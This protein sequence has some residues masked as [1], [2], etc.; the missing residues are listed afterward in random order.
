MVG[1]A[2]DDVVNDRDAHDLARLAQLRR[3]FQ[4]GVAG[5]AVAGGM[6]V[7]Q[8]HAGGVVED[9]GAEQFARMHEAGRGGADGDGMHGN[10]LHARVYGDRQEMLLRAVAQRLQDGQGGFGRGGVLAGGIGEDGAVGKGE[11]DDHGRRSDLFR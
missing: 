4:V 9:G 10:D 3:G 8:D 1:L 7:G 11:G 6:V 2:D 5:G